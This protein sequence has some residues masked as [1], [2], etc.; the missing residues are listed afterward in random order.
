MRRTAATAALATVAVLLLPAVPASACSFPHG[1]F[2]LSRDPVPAGARV[3]LSGDVIADNKGQMDFSCPPLPH[4]T[5]SPSP[6][7]P[8]Q[9]TVSEEPLP[10]ESESQVVVIPTLV[11]VAFHAPADPATLVTV[12]I[13][14][15]REWNEP[16]APRRTIAWLIPNENRPWGDPADGLYEWSFAG[17]VTI[18]AGLRA[19]R[20]ELAAFQRIGVNYGYVFVEVT[21][22]LPSTG[23]DVTRLALLGLLAAGTATA[24]ARRRHA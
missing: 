2:H 12:T 8:D 23:T 14:E 16:A 15:A 6:T 3:R 24:A 20:Y 10:E 19:G 21:D 22:G 9:I 17:D 5:P 13:A 1:F 4:P 11:P 7:R 18:P